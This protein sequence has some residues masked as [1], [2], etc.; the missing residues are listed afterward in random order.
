MEFWWWI[1]LGAVVVISGTVIL[2]RRAVRS[3]PDPTQLTFE[4]ALIAEIEQL[5]AQGRQVEA[6]AV[7]RRAT[8]LNLLNA[9]VIVDRV[10]RRRRERAAGG[11]ASTGRSPARGPEPVARVD[12]APPPVSEGPSVSEIDLDTELHARGLVADG[13]RTDAVNLVRARTDWDTEQA[14]RFV[15]SL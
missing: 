1:L 7:L 12:P 15:D 6:I 10:D 11:A 2:S 8:G 9:K 5:C 3:G 4:P 13:R 14:A